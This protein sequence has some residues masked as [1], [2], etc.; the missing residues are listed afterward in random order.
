MNT[1]IFQIY[2]DEETRLK[3]SS[4]VIPYDNSFRFDPLYFE[5]RVILDLYESGEFDTEDYVGVIST[6]IEEKTKKTV[7]YFKQKMEQRESKDI[8]IWCAYEGDVACNFWNNTF[9]LSRLLCALINK[10]Y[11]TLLPFT[12]NNETW[13][14][15][16]CNFGIM[17]GDVM[18]SYVELV[19]K[20]VMNFLET[21]KDEDILHILSHQI[22]HRGKPTPIHAFFLE[23]L[24][25]SF[26]GNSSYTHST[27]S[28]SMDYFTK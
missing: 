12:I 13:E 10:R 7:K 4:D 18:N 2:Y 24:M 20:P 26:I 28:H 16:Y 15:C 27:L 5:N 3:L 21:T 25:G 14:N 8:Y 1:K 19:L 9:I 11:P 22:H 23:G 17:R 6:R